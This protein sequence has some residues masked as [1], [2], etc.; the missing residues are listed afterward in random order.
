M[1]DDL[2]SGHD[3]RDIKARLDTIVR[4]A[5]MVTPAEATALVNEFNRMDALVPIFDPTWFLANMHNME[6]HKRIAQ[7]FAAFRGEIEAVL[8]EE[9]QEKG[10]GC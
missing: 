7:A 1:P 2:R 10:R 8:E 4:I 9:R 5:L 3:L 6:H